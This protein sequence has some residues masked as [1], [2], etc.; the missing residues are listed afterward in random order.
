MTANSSLSETYTNLIK[1]SIMADN[2][3]INEIVE[4]IKETG[5]KAVE[6][7]KEAGEKAQEKVQEKVEEIKK[8]IDD[9]TPEI[10]PKDAKDNMVMAILAYLGILVIIPMI[11]AKD[12]K[13]AKFH[14]NQGLVLFLISIACGICSKIQKIGWGFY[15]INIVIVVFAIIGIVYAAQGKA[16]ELPV[17]GNWKILK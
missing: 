5:E 16:K 7:I 14:T 6:Q 13:F 2:E 8:E 17:V 15:I 3:K 1:N 11:F 10:D 4:E 12:S 9:F